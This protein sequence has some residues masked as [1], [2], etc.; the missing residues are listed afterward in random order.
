[1][2]VKISLLEVEGE[3]HLVVGYALKR[4]RAFARLTAAELEVAEGL[5]EG[6]SSRAL[7]RRRAV[8]E[9]TVANQLAR[10]YQKLGVSSKHELL[11]LVSG[12]RPEPEG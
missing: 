4:P 10:I 3:S 6:L 1:M 2:S 12:S 8:S 11:A 7:A 9:R 5:I